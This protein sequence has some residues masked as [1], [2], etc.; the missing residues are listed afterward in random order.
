[1]CRR[2]LIL[3]VRD[4]V[5]DDLRLGLRRWVDDHSVRVVMATLAA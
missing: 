1:L 4:E 2:R 3:V 5:D